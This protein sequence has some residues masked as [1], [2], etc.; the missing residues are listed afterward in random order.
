MKNVHQVY[1]NAHLI[2]KF[3]TSLGQ[4]YFEKKGYKLYSLSILNI[5]YKY[6]EAP[7]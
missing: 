6:S 3:N 7:F 4:L 1:I 5:I 2:N